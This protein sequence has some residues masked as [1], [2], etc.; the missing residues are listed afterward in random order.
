[1]TTKSFKREKVITSPKD[2]AKIVSFIKKYGLKVVKIGKGTEYLSLAHYYLTNK[3][4]SLYHS[5]IIEL[6]DTKLQLTTRYLENKPCTYIFNLN[7]EDIFSNSGHKCF[8][9][10]SKYWKVPKACT[11]ENEKLDRMFDSET[12]KYTCSA[13][14]TIGFNHYFQGQIIEDVYE[15]DLNSAYSSVLVD[16]MPDLYHPLFKKCHLVKKGFI[17]FLLNENLTLVEEGSYADVSFPLI[18]SPDKLKE[19]VKKWF[20]KKRSSTGVQKLEAKAMLNLPIG[21]CQRYNPFLR[22]YIVHKCNHRILDLIDKDTLFWNTDAI[23]S[24]VKR[25]DLPIGNSIG[26]FKEIHYNKVRYV[27]NTYQCDDELPV[28][29]GIPKAWFKRF[30]IEHGRPYDILKDDPPVCNNYYSWN[31]ETLKLEKNYEEIE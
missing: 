16:K 23:F 14:P 25:T 28:Y 20:E 24:K 7:N 22:G 29:R 1:M 27:G 2:V 4:L 9:E 18:S 30:E 5:V 12:G 6:K 26:Q 19:F 17:G 10:F 13:S 15:Y 3:P 21:Y 8:A 11:Y 31:W